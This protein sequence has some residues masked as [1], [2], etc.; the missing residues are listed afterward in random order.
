MDPLPRI[1]PPAIPLMRTFRS[2]STAIPTFLQDLLLDWTSR[3]PC[4]H[5]NRLNELIKHVQFC[6]AL[7]SF[8]QGKIWYSVRGI[9][10][11]GLLANEHF[12]RDGRQLRNLL[13]HDIHY[14]IH[15]YSPVHKKISVARRKQELSL[16]SPRPG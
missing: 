16:M 12:F 3:V 7:N 13:L 1:L 10:Q 4:E 2:D 5:L 6:V 9:L 15:P 11:K 14:R 8:D